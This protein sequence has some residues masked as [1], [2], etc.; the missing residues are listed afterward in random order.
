MKQVTT[1]GYEEI[2]QFSV[3]LGQHSVE[4]VSK[5]GLPDWDQVPPATVLLALYPQLLP[6]DHILLFGSHH[7]ALAVV[8]AHSAHEG[9]LYITDNNS[10]AL[11]MTRDF[12]CKQYY[13]FSAHVD[14]PQT[15]DFNINHHSKS[16]KSQA[17]PSMAAASLP[18]VGT[19]W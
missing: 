3:N 6:T 18:G 5:P 12:G 16:K 2:S 11:E 10:T 19:W 8:L 4:V 1:R 15:H 7:G 13:R 14:I 9:Q 17:C